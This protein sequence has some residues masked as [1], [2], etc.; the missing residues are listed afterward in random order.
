MPAFDCDSN[1]Y[2]AHKTAG[3]QVAAGCPPPAPFLRPRR[4]SGGR[5]RGV[6]TLQLQ[7]AADMIQPVQGSTLRQGAETVLKHGRFSEQS[8]DGQ[9][10]E[11]RAP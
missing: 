2:M 10:T 5:R 6:G 7:R 4:A 3:T 8:E 11:L 1:R 9:R